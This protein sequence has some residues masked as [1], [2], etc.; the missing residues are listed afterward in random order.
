MGDADESYDFANLDS[1][2]IELRKGSELVMGNRFLGG[3]E[4]GAMPW[5]HKYIG[6]PALSFI[7]RLFFKVKVGD[8]HCGLRG[9]RRQS[10]FELGLITTGM[11]FASEMIVKSALRGKRIVEVPTTLS[12]EGRSRKPHL[13]T[14]SDGWR[15]L[16]FLLALSPT[17][18]FLYPGL[19]IMALSLSFS[20]RLLYGPIETETITLDVHTL[21]YSSFGVLIGIQMILFYALTRIFSTSVGLISE[22]S[23][24]R[25]FLSYFTLERGLA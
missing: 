8:F 14:W 9:F 16:R 15:H 23:R 20:L 19:T 10:I 25:R 17:W 1:F 7:G 3:I 4:K 12:P 13:R 22:T 21:I 24:Q 6:N 5:L 2:V 11:E 18:V